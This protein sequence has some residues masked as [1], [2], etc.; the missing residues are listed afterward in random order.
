MKTPVKQS[1]AEFVAERMKRHREECDGMD[2]DP[3]YAMA[4]GTH[5]DRPIS[6]QEYD[7]YCFAP[8]WHS[9]RQAG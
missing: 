2:D 6:Q 4:R 9:R 5:V 1:E 8:G 7:A 3:L